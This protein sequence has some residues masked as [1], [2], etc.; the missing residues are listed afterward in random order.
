VAGLPDMLGT[1][2]FGRCCHFSHRELTD[3][4]SRVEEELP[5]ISF[6]GDEMLPPS[7]CKRSTRNIP[8]KMDSAAIA[9]PQGA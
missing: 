2:L 9:S 6:T 7:E 5:K 3:M 4:Y 8:S 1:C